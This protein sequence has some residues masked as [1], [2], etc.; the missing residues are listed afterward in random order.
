M[1][2]TGPGPDRGVYPGSFDPLTT[3]HL[4]VAEAARRAHDLTEVHLAVSRVALDKEA[5]TVPLFRHRLD[6]L[7]RAVARRGWLRLVVTDRQLIAD[8]A[9]GYGVVV[10]GADKWAQVHDLRFYR[11][12]QARDEAVARLPTPAIAPRPPHPV[13]AAGRLDLPDDVAAVSSTRAR[14]GGHRLMAPEA[15]DFDRR[16]GAWTDP[17]RYRRWIE[18]ADGGADGGADD[19]GVTPR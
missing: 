4:A 1:D 11:S 18:R 6:V 12:E 15:A 10:M 2:R 19:E 5:T 8:I 17:E 3:A 16:T 14:A 13:P 9:E 7:R